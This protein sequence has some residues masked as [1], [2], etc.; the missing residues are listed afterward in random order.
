MEAQ[1]IAAATAW[2]SLPFTGLGFDLGMV[3]ARA[4]RV[5][6]S[7][8]EEGMA[9]APRANFPVT[10]LAAGYELQ[11]RLGREIRGC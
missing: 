8:P 3:R 11:V 10:W 4:E 2:D 1:R 9:D 5:S 7:V 6:F